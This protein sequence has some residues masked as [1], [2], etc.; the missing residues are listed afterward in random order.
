MLYFKFKYDL[1]INPKKWFLPKSIQSDLN[2]KKLEILDWII[3]FDEEKNYVNREIGMGVNGVVI[4][5]APSEK[6]YGFWSDADLKI[7]DFDKF[8]PKKTS[9]KEFNSLWKD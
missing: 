5:Q 4:Y 8:N 1:T 6:H 2:T 7:L 3:E 9:E